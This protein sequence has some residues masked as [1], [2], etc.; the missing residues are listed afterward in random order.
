MPRTLITLC[1]LCVATTAMAQ[2]ERSVVAFET[3]TIQV[4][5]PRGGDFGNRFFNIEGLSFEER[6]RSY[7]TVR[8]NLADLRAEFDGLFPGGWRVTG[9]AL[10]L[11]QDNAA[12]TSDGFVDVYLSTDDTSDAKTALSDLQYPFFDPNTFEPDM[13]LA[14]DSPI[15]SFLFFEVATGAIDRF[16]QAGG[17][18]G[19]VEALSLTAELA[20][21]IENDGVLTMVF[22]DASETV[23]A[24][25]RGQEGF[26]GRVGPNLFI[27]VEGDGGTGCPADIDGDGQLTI[28][29]FLEFQNLFAAG[30]LRADFDG[31][32]SLTLFDFLDFQ[33]QFAAGC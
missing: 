7:G 22:V 24:T 23:A 3:G 18:G 28:F 11:T 16:D 13:P 21:D 2:E 8:W 4:T 10:E 31:D 29:D 17:P 5:G 26:E 14:S 32:G 6:F 30:D 19:G 20:S 1:G 15:L 33:N 25:Y 12:F 27:T 9:V